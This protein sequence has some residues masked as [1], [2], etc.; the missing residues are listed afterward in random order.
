[1]LKVAVTGN[2]GSGKSTVT[3]IF[4]SLDVPVFIADEVARNLYN[5]DEVKEL[6]AERF[7]KEVFDENGQLIKPRLADIIFNDKT[8]LHDINEIIHPRTLEKY[9]EWQQGY[10][11]EAYTIHESA[12]LFENNLQRHFD[13]IIN[14][15]APIEI[16][17]K[18]V[19]ERDGSSKKEVEERMKNQLSDEEKNMMSDFVV[20]NDGETFLIPQII[21]IDKKLRK[22]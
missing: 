9:Q 2:I 12:I 18:R 7:G 8:A 20:L 15:S 10:L 11:D 4:R 3:N 14:V 19:V 17:L 21:E 22:I 13:F 1:M 5:E 6:V 16:R